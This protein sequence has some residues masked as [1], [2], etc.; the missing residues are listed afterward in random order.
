MCRTAA[1]SSACFCQVFPKSREINKAGMLFLP[2]SYIEN[3]R[4]SG[5]I[6]I[7]YI[8][9]KGSEGGQNDFV[10]MIG[11]HLHALELRKALG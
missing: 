3:I 5:S 9:P 8:S 4:I 7:A 6:A 10:G 2:G 11:I 1:G